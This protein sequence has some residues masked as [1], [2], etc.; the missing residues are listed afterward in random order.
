MQKTPEEVLNMVKRRKLVQFGY[1]MRGMTY[2]I[3]QLVIKNKM[4]GKRLIDK[5][6]ISWMKDLCYC[7]DTHPP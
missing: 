1:I 3:L 4:E 5:L 2:E 7:S 6:K